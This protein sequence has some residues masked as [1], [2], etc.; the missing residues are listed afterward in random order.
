MRP[1][2]H[3]FAVVFRNRTWKTQFSSFVENVSVIVRIASIFLLFNNKG[4]NL[5]YSH[6]FSQN[7]KETHELYKQE[8]G[9]RKVKYSAAVF[10]YVPVL[11]A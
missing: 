6:N 5:V 7:K 11:A 1:P 8:K 9:K 10:I 4:S 3:F 2:G